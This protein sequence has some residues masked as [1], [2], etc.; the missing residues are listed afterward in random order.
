MS[1]FFEYWSDVRYQEAVALFHI[2]IP[3]ESP[4]AGC[5]HMS[6]IRL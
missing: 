4:G 2:G 5:R 1:R 3:I 6:S